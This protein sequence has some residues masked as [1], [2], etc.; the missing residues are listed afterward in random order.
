M[1]P[2]EGSGDVGSLET[3]ARKIEE[4]RHRVRIA[5]QE[6][7]QADL[8]T[9]EARERAERERAERERAERESAEREAQAEREAREARDKVYEAATDRFREMAAQAARN[10]AV[11]ERKTHDI[12]KHAGRIKRR[13]LRF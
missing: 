3:N 1:D 5:M 12:T 13:Q 6:N 4:N 9:R 10:K 8:A 2:P 7:A 11:N